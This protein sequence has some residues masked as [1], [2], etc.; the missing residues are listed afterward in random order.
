VRWNYLHSLDPTGKTFQDA[1]TKAA[2]TQLP[3]MQAAGA[4]FSTAAEALID[5]TAMGDDGDATFKE[6]TDKYT[7]LLI[8]DYAS[9]NGKQ[10][11]QDFDHYLQQYF[12][13]ARENDPKDFDATVVAAVG[14][15]ATYAQLN[16]Q[17]INS[18]RG[19]PIL[20]AQYTF[21]RPSNQPAT[22]DFT[23]IFAES[24]RTGGQLT[25]NGAA[26]IYNSVPAGAAYGRLKDL[27]VS[28][29]LDQSIGDKTS[30]PLT[31]SLAGYGQYQFDPSVLNITSANLAPGTNISLPANAQV[32]LGTSG[33]LGIVQA[34]LTLNLQKSISIPLAIKWSNKTDLLQAQDVRGQVGISYDF[35]SLLK[36]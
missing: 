3:D 10:L 1:W 8:A 31:F 21:S 25:A 20:T 16:Q 28:A 32:L 34:K 11:V 2:T 22:H 26:S 12:A 17:V 29:E 15:L 19:V 4:A 5:A 14:A 24:W 27:Q 9:Q 30:P 18:A 33:W 23:M 36:Q 7:P 6:L 35:S 13:H